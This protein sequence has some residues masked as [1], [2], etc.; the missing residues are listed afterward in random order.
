VASPSTTHTDECLSILSEKH[1]QEAKTT[2][3]LRSHVGST[4][5]GSRVHD[6]WCFGLSGLPPHIRDL[7]RA[8]LLIGTGVSPFATGDLWVLP[9]ILGFSVLPNHI[10]MSKN[11]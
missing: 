6:Q 11:G 2:W 8:T 3:H 5:S 4:I 1:T 9:S 7:A 10:A